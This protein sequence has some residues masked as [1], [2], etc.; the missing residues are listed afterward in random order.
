MPTVQPPTKSRHKIHHSPGTCAHPTYLASHD[1]LN[2]AP[3]I[4]IGGGRWC[5]P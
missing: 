4:K 5:R 3:S 1:P 2:D